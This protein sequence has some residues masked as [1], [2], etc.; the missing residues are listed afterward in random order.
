MSRTLAAV[1]A[2]LV[3]LLSVATARADGE[4][5]LVVQNGDATETYCVPFTGESIAGDA[6]L[7]RAGI[8][9]E[10]FGG[11]GGRTVC[12]LDDVGCFDAG[13]FNDCFCQCQGGNCTYWAFF[14]QKYGAG[15]VYSSVAFNLSRARDGDLQGWKWG[16]GA[17]Q[18][19]PAPTPITFEDVC[20][21]APRGAAVLATATPTATVPATAT[22]TAPPP[23]ASATAAAPSA[24]TPAHGQS[25]TATSSA[26]V[27]STIA[28]APATTGAPSRTPAEV[29]ITIV[30]RSGTAPAAPATGSPGNGEGGGVPAGVIAFGVVV[31]VLVLSLAAA[32]AV[33]RRHGA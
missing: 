27:S 21:H 19:A 7:E 31:A 9:V 13:S 5:G 22:T 32:V 8:T 28:G 10:Q 20:G 3:A 2:T 15:W 33:R 29:T 18:S 4:A 17:Q 14:T 6:V 1:I 11:T 26:G 12:A 16:R 25:A 24:G 30:S 23:A